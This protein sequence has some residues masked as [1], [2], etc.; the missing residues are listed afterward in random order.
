MR[1]AL[2]FTVNLAGSKRLLMCY[3]LIGM[4]QVGLSTMALNYV[5]KEDSAYAVTA[6]GV[7]L[8]VV[9]KAEMVK[10]DIDEI[11]ATPTVRL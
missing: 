8:N 9:K 4:L 2:N 11:L 5:K 1:G 6:T 10:Q 3:V 7:P